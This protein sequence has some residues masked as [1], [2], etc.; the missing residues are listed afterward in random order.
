MARGDVGDAMV[1]LDLARAAEARQ[2]SQELGPP[3]VCDVRN[4]ELASAD[5]VEPIAADRGIHAAAAAEVFGDGECRAELVLRVA[6]LGGCVLGMGC[7]HG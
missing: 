1:D 3:R 2:L 4:V 6:A 5:G 7:R